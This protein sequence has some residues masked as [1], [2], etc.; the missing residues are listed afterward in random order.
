MG[1]STEIPRSASTKIRGTR[2]EFPAARPGGSA[3]AVAA[4]ECIA[5]LGTDTGGSIR[6]PAALVRLCRLETDLWASVTLRL[7]AFASSLDQIGPSQKDVRDS[8]TML[9]F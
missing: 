3:A 4:D 7:V 2:R 6:Q 5:S 9:E 1:S 8:A